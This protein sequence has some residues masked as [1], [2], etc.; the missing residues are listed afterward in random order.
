MRFSTSYNFHQTIPHGLMINGLTSFRS[1]LRGRKSRDSVPLKAARDHARMIRLLC[2]CGVVFSTQ[3]DI[4]EYLCE[5]EFIF[6]KAL[7]FF[8]Q[9]PR[10]DL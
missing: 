4:F 9:G 8:H 5:C 2:A 6:E 1:L 3:I 7:A 10:T